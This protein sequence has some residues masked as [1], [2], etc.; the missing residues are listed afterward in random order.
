MEIPSPSQPWSGQTNC[1]SLSRRRT[2][3]HDFPLSPGMGI[4]ACGHGEDRKIEQ[5]EERSPSTKKRLPCWNR[6]SPHWSEPRCSVLGN[7]PVETFPCRILYCLLHL[8]QGV[9]FH[10]MLAAA[11]LQTR[12]VGVRKETAVL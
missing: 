9:S 6:G 2:P 10:P 8:G 7:Q 1:Q 5:D 11:L 12:L 4:P 3:D